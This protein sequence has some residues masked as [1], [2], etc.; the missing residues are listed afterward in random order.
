M[1]KIKVNGKEYLV[2]EEI[3]LLQFLKRKGVYVPYLCYH[4]YLRP[5]GSCRICIVQ[6]RGR[7]RNS[8]ATYIEDGMDIQTDTPEIIQ[9][10]KWMLQ[11]LFGERNHYCMYCAV[12]NDCEFQNLG[13]YTGL[14]H[15]HFPTFKNIFDLDNSHPYILFDNN[16]C[17]LCSRCIRVCSEVAGHFVL[18][19]NNKGISSMIVA[20]GGKKLGESLCTSCGLCVQVCPTGTF[21]DK[22]SMYLGRSWESQKYQSF[23]FACP[24]GC[25]IEI[26]NR[27]GNINKVYSDWDSFT[28]GLICYKGR[29]ES[30]INYRELKQK[31]LPTFDLLNNYEI[32]SNQVNSKSV[33]IIDGTLFNEE[34]EKIKKIFNNIF[35]L[36]DINPKVLQN[37]ITFEELDNYSV[38]VVDNWDINKEYGAIGSVLKRNSYYKKAKII[39]YKDLVNN[40]EKYSFNEEKVIFIY[41][42]Y[43]SL[44]PENCKNKNEINSIL[45]NSE[46]LVL[47]LKANSIGLIK[48]LG[49]EADVVNNFTDIL[50]NFEKI[51]VFSREVNDIDQ[52]FLSLPKVKVYLLPFWFEINGSF[53]N[54]FNQLLNIK[55]LYQME[56]SV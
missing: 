13:Y 22:Y 52:E 18:S 56:A 8:C 53:Y 40:F 21:I 43:L 39:Q 41:K 29:Y 45:E 48:I 44:L 54:V 7:Y 55:N 38:Y 32:L 2:E 10:R 19:E 23:C 31:K 42:N 33:V 5:V 17:V 50:E 27:K 12:T 34:I 30:V 46:H 9:M 1:K 36:D 15:F 3:T 14:D 16:R 35:I 6:D 11:F 4:P 49:K 37:K 20:D 28:K 47:P 51:F 24:V 26:Y 25:G